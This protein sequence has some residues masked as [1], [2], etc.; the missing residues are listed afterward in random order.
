MATGPKVLY[1]FGPFRI[2]PDKQVLLRENQP[3]A[4]THK[5][6]ETLL[7]L[8]RNSREVVSKDELMKAVWPDAFVEEANLSQNISALRKVLGDTPEDR[9][10]I[11]TLPGRGYRFTA[12]VRA[13]TQDGEDVVIESRSRSQMIVEQTREAAKESLVELP[14]TVRRRASRKYLLAIGAVL[15]VGLL[16]LGA[17]FLS[18][19]RPPVSL[20]EKDFVLIADFTNATGDP[21][22]DD[23]LRQGLAAQLEQSPFLSLVPEDRIQQTLALMS[24]PVDARLTPE[25]AR[26]VCQRTGS[27]AVLEGSIAPLGSQYV[28][29]LRAQNCLTGAL[30][31]QEQVQAAR[32]EDVLKALSQVASRFR[33]R[34]GESLTAVAKHDVPLEDATTSSLEAWKAYSQGWRVLNAKGEAAAI[35]FFKRA[36]EIDSEFAAAYASLALMY[37]S[38]S[39]SVLATENSGKAYDLRDRASDNERFFITAYYEGRATGNQE[40]AEQT[41]ETWAEAYPRDF[42]PHSFLAGF[43]YPVLGKYEKAIQESEKTMELDPNKG[44]GYTALGYASLYLGRLDAAED[45]V[46]RASKHKIEGPILSLLRYDVAFLKGDTAAMQREMAA[47]EGK[48]GTEDRMLDHAAFALAYAGHMRAARSMSQFAIDLAQQEAHPER[49][50]LFETREALW[51]AFYGNPQAAKQ[52]AK[53]ALA[54]AD[55]REVKYGVAVALAI[56][57]DSSQAETLANDLEKS[58]PEDT[59][60][61]FNYLP[62]LRATLALNRKDPAKAIEL[63]QIASPYELGTPR[64]N[65]DGFFGAL[66]PV[67]VRGQAYLAAR[68]G[69]QA[70]AEFQKMLDHPGITVGDPVA[71]L[72]H[73]GLARAYALQGETAKARAQY[74]Q[75]FALWKNAD[76]DIPALRQAQDE[77]AKLQ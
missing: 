67:L 10:Y 19:K 73:V 63:L 45:A 61:K 64:S 54:L 44:I 43:I 58:F 1:E 68:Q 7:I 18:R 41:C 42:R 30:L 70:A 48:P 24:Q 77:Y 57:G 40:K 75:F 20:G 8:V 51:E 33:T 26:E 15:G 21:L 17:A 11:V 47:S 60:V 71:V 25:I 2:D 74:Q 32:K 76:P 50:A 27:A 46:R 49:A 3:V 22:F 31:D 16:V 66:Y 56:A 53:K 36:V 62:V 5:A 9:R 39:E 38:M 72:A 29:G 28:V 6:F 12:E 69:P 55:S 13:V 37:G 23:T 59:S 4:I 65:L 52:K 35:P 34:V 14:I